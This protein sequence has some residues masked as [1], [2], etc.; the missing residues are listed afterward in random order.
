[1]AFLISRSFEFESFAPNLTGYDRFLLPVFQKFH[2]GRAVSLTSELAPYPVAL[3]DEPGTRKTK[4]SLLDSFS[5]ID[6]HPDSGTE[7][8][9]MDGGFLLHQVVTS[10]YFVQLRIALSPRLKQGKDPKRR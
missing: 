6:I 1:M 10:L 7:N 3:F 2:F 9:V 8:C 4:S 5:S